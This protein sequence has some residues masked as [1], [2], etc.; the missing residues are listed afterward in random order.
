[1][2][3]KKGYRVIRMMIT[4]GRE[5]FVIDIADSTGTVRRARMIMEDVVKKMEDVV[6]KKEGRNDF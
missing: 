5:D 6:K 2:L 1:M 4:V 3:T